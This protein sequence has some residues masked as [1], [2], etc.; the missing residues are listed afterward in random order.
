M[1]FEEAL[2]VALYNDL[3]EIQKYMYKLS[4]ELGIKNIMIEMK[5][6]GDEFEGKGFAVKLDKRDEIEQNKNYLSYLENIYTSRFSI[7]DGY[8]IH[9][10]DLIKEREIDK[11][12]LEKIISKIEFRSM[13]IHEI[14]IYLYLD[15]NLNHSYKRIRIYFSRNIDCDKYEEMNNK[16][17][18]S[19]FFGNSSSKKTKTSERISFK[20]TD[21]NKQYEYPKDHRFLYM[22]YKDK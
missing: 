18:E 14:T 17:K 4:C 21:V 22:I 12:G 7:K 8:S 10:G 9:F 1:S 20:Y 19:H 16:F 3:K 5:I 11:G 2:K 6:N 13:G 15:P